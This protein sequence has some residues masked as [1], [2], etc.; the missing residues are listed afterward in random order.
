[1]NAG[2]AFNLQKLTVTPQVGLEYR[3]LDGDSYTEDGGL[4]LSVNQRT[5]EFLES[6]IGVSVAGEYRLRDDL[7]LRPMAQVGL[8]YDVIGEA[9]EQTVSIAGGTPAALSSDNPSNLR[10]ELRAGLDLS[11]GENTTVSVG[12]QGEVSSEFTSNGGF[13]RLRV[14]I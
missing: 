3:Q 8:I 7:I 1:M 10:G 11:V 14:D 2:Y 9:R 5:H 12:Y 13:L 4:G 6:R